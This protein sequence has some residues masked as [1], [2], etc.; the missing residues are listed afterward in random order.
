VDIVVE[1][2]LKIYD[3]AALVPIINGAGGFITT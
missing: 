3:V 2:D 1:S